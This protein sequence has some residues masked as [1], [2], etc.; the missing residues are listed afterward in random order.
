MPKVSVIM[1]VYNTNEEY[2]KVS[3]RSII[4]QTFTDF[5]FIIVNDG[6]TNNAE[7]VI[8]SFND[9]RI[10]YYSYGENKGASFARNYAIDRAEGEYIAFVD[11]DDITIKD[12]LEKHV[13][14]LD[15]NPDVGV[16]SSLGDICNS[17]GEIIFHNEVNNQFKTSEELK[18]LVL[19]FCPATQG[20]ATI[21]KSVIEK[22]DETL[23]IA[24]DYEL[25]TRLI[26]K[27]NFISLNDVH[28]I[29]RWHEN[30]LSNSHIM[31][32]REKPL[33]RLL[34]VYFPNLSEDEK[35]LFAKCY[36]GKVKISEY[37]KIKIVC[38]KMITS[39]K[40]IKNL[41]SVI[42]ERYLYQ[43]IIRPNN[44]INRILRIIINLIPV[45]NI[46]E[47]VRNKLKGRESI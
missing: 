40:T 27:T 39:A 13:I 33:K 5:E 8:K 44:L 24:E 36:H 38:S 37:K 42:L 16:V 6:S 22:Y 12:R 7:E 35:T 21:R 45:K 10:K 29:I 9:R 43:L 3:I 18:V 23:K 31:N 19:F 14:Y 1:P 17:N 20:C 32:S 28:L 25:W 15:L 2:L 11:S 41:D 34:S 4:E 26:L 46:R 30:N 47:L